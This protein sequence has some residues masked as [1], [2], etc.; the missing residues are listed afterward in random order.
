MFPIKQFDHEVLCEQ[1]WRLGSM[2][3][4]G[5]EVLCKNN[6]TGHYN[7]ISPGFSHYILITLCSWRRSL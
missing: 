2:I 3:S 1:R 5:N 6:V 4:V 7:R